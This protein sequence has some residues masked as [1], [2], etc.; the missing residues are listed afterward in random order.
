[1]GQHLPPRWVYSAM[2]CLLL[3]FLLP[4]DLHPNILFEE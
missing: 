3:S 2:A 1:M 4:H